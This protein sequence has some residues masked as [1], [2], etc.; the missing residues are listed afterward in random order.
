MF[1]NISAVLKYV[2]FPV[3]KWNIITVFKTK[4]LF[5]HRLVGDVEVGSNKDQGFVLPSLIS[6]IP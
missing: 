5:R 4:V 1:Q 6:T 2:V 3:Y